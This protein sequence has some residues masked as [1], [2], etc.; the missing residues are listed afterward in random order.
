[1][2]PEETY[3]AIR[4]AY[5]DCKPAPAYLEIHSRLLYEIF[6]DLNMR[7][8]PQPGKLAGVEVRTHSKLVGW[9]VVA[10]PYMEME[11]M[12]I[13]E[14]PEYYEPERKPP[15]PKN[16]QSPDFDDTERN[17]YEAARQDYLDRRMKY[18]GYR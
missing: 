9:R 12:G 8:R 16:V 11:R 3:N 2:T 17:V 1:M 15:E 6:S 14:I 18:R 5:R 7:E 10:R 13:E 4:Q